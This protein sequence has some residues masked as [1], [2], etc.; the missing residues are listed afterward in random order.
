M[1]KVRATYLPRSDMVFDV[2]YY[3]RVHVPL[4][5]AQTAGRVNILRIDV[6]TDA[7]LLFNPEGKRAPC[8]FSVYFDT[9]QD[10][11]QFRDFLGSEQVEPLRDDVA[12]YTNCELEWTVSKVN[13]VR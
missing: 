11:E 10:V 5:K 4:A 2:E 8:V 6:E 9:E 12:N 1:Y 7:A 3:F 13:D